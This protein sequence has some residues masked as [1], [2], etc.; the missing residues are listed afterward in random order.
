LNIDYGSPFERI[1]YAELFE[2]EVGFPM[3]D[4]DKVRAKANEAGPEDQGRQGQ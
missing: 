2:R 4:T 1:R 3:T